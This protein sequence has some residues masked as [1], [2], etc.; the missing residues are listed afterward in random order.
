MA[1]RVAIDGL[2]RIFRSAPTDRAVEAVR[3]VTA[4]PAE[5]ASSR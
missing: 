5:A 2:G 4:M 1:A 3:I